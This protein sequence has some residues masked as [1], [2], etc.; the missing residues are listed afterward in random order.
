MTERL[1]YR[2]ARQR[3]FS[4]RVIEAADERRRIYLD[5]TAFYPTSGGQPHDLGLLG[6]RRVVDVV[7][8]GDRIAHLLADPLDPTVVAVEGSID[9]PRRHDHM[10]QHTGQHLLSAVCDDLLGLRTVSVHFG[11]ASSTLDLEGEAA[12]SGLLD[13]AMLTRIEDRANALV[14]EARPVTVSFEEAD[15]AA[16]LRK[17][18]DRTGT[19]RIVSIEGID[20]SACGGTHVAS[21]SEIGPLVIR[22]QDRIRSALRLEFL[23]G[24]RARSRARQDHAQL[25]AIARSF[26]ASLDEVGSLVERQSAQ[27]R[28]AQ[29]ELQRLTEQL[30]VLRAEALHRA[31]EP[32]VDGIRWI[33]ERVARGGADTNRSLALAV[34]R[35]PRAAFIAVSHDPPSVLLSTSADSDIDAGRVLRPLLQSSG[36]RGGGSARLAQGS[37]PSPAAA[38]AIVTHL[39][40][41]DARLANPEHPDHA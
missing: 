39:I 4:A 6:G 38:D 16:A 14:A 26:S 41:A 7:D 18:S 19:L 35:L 30:A 11:P 36:G 24:D 2:D 29:S 5:R 27:L 40:E 13:G 32:G 33:V 37:V 22:G 12:A 8:E 34:A 9:W 1:Y 28:D 25:S 15:S 31:V 10:Q 20:R 23:C 3:T 17:A 21:T